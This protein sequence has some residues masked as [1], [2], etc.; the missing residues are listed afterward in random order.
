MA[1]MEQGRSQAGLAGRL[2][3]SPQTANALETGKY[4]PSLHLAFKLAALFA[5][6][7]EDMFKPDG[8]EK[9]I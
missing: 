1:R 7:L 9:Y 2:N 3:F 6:K 5:C 4:D 8:E